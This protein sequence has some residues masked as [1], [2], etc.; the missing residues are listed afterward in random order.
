MRTAKDGVMD[1][2]FERPLEG[3]INARRRAIILGLPATLLGA[4]AGLPAASGPPAAAPSLAVGD[5]WVYNCSDGYRTQVR[6]T[7]TREI[8]AIDPAG[9]TMRVTGRGD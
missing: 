5:R 2:K 7:E 4:C 6:W 8:S 3:G 1:T 9:I